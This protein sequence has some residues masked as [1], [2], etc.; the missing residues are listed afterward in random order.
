MSENQSVKVIFLGDTNVGK[1][2]IINKQREN[3]ADPLPTIN[4]AN[5][6]ITVKERTLELIDTAGQER[7]RSLTRSYYTQASIAIFVFDVT[8]SQSFESLRLFY[9]DLTDANGSAKIVLAGNK[10]DLENQRQVSNEEIKKYAD[11]LDCTYFLT[12]A[13]TGANINELFDYVADMAT[14]CITPITKIDIT[15]NENQ[16]KSNCC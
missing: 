7:F 5:S 4:T 9:R 8:S 2:S 10:V 1:T 12:S 3:Y 15:P 14:E 13:I 6:Y 11:D 16:D